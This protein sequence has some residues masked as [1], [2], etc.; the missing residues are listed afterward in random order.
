M[1]NQPRMWSAGLQDIE[2]VGLKELQSTSVTC[3]VDINRDN[4][5]LWNKLEM[6]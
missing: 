2:D 5:K 4:Y 6:G 1:V 3:D